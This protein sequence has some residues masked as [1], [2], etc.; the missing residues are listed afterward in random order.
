MKY[1]IETNPTGYVETLEVGGR[2]YRKEWELTDE[3]AVCRNKEFHEQ[4]EADGWPEKVLGA[5]YERI[6]DSDFPYGFGRLAKK[7]GAAAAEASA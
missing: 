2:E 3:G 1:T 4:L 5:V 6:D 7:M